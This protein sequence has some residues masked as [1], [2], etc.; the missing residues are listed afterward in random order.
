[1]S[2]DVQS[3]NIPSIRHITLIQQAVDLLRAQRIE[4]RK[5]TSNELRTITRASQYVDHLTPVGELQAGFE[6]L[7]SE[8]RLAFRASREPDANVTIERSAVSFEAN[9]ED[10]SVGYAQVGEHCRGLLVMNADHGPGVE[11]VWMCSHFHPGPHTA[12][13][14]ARDELRS[15]MEGLNA[16]PV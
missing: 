6:A 10:L 1:M 8:L 3:Q 12:E 5:L 7:A 13:A 15:R 16:G 14:C 11:T 4:K 2:L 9:L